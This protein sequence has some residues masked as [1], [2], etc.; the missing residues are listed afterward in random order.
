[1]LG[2]SSTTKMR[3]FSAMSA[4]FLNSYFPFTA[5]VHRSRRELGI[6]LMPTG[7]LILLRRQKD[8]ERGT[9]AQFAVHPDLSAMGVHQSFG[10]GQS[11]AH[12]GRGAVHTH[13]I[14]E[15]FLMILRGD[16][17]AVIRHANLHRIGCPHI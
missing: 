11:Q 4:R 9:A 5:P 15:N 7:C 3:S 16:A 6:C 10:N 12:S 14:L 8:V 1:M 13:E 2:S 17:L